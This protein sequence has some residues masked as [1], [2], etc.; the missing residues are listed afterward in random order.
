M[1]SIRPTAIERMVRIAAPLEAVWKALTKDGLSNLHLLREGEESRLAEGHAL[2]WYHLEDPGTEPRMKGRVIVVAPPRHLAFLAFS[3]AKGV[4]DVP[5]NYT[6][7]DITLRQEEDGRTL[8]TV[9]HGDFA[10]QPHGVRRATEAGNKWVEVLVRLKERVE[11]QAA[12]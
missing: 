1:S 3:P 10:G 7:V 11:H 12:A 9:Q 2:A 8:V 4:P 5:E 6:L